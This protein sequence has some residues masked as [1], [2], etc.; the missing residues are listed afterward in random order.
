MVKALRGA[1][2][3]DEDTEKELQKKVSLLFR[4]MVRQNSLSCDDIISIIFSQTTDISF[5]PAKALRL[6]ENLHSTPLFCTQ[7][8][9]CVDFPQKRMLRILLS[10]NSEDP[11]ASRSVYLGAASSLRRDL[12][13]EKNDT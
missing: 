6:T 5:N 3:L 12:S 8:P 1:I 13:R 9:V 2:S 10:C 11:R 7:E 4:E